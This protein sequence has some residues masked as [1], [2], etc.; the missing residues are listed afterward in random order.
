[1]L[2][3][4]FWEKYFKVYDVLNLCIPYQEMHKKIINEL[5]I[6][7]NEVILDAGA[8]TGN[9]AS[10]IKKRGARVIAL[11]SSE[12]ALQLCLKKNKYIKVIHYDLREKLVFPDDYFDR[13]VSVNTLFLI[14]PHFRS[15]VVKEL[16]RV[17][18]KNGKIVLV[19]LQEGF[20]PL[21]IYFEHSRRIKEKEGLFKATKQMLKFIIPSF[22]ILYY[23]KKIERESQ[24]RKEFFK[25]EE[26]IQLLK[27]AGFKRISATERV[28]ANQAFLNSAY[29]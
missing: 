11:D 4:K 20:R 19:N 10:E 23:A 17:L 25:K 24:Q 29:K 26:Q 6:Q 8:G 1:M 21:K 27:K 3:Y 5:E 22:Q 15:T 28:Y 12:A 14:E 7:P 18:K 16:Y 13:V 9:L 2:D